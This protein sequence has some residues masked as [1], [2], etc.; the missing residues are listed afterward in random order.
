MERFLLARPDYTLR[1]VGARTRFE[2]ASAAA[3]ALRD[4]TV[5]VVVGALPFETDTPAALV[6]PD[7][8]S[9]DAARPAPGP[10]PSARIVAE[11]PSQSEHV[12]R[13]TRL[14]KLLGEGTLRKVVAARAV[15]LAADTPIDPEA[16]VGHMLRRFPHANGFIVEVGAQL[17]VGASPELLVRRAGAEVTLFPLAGTAPRHA[18]PA[19]DQ[20][21][22]QDLLASEKN[23]AEHSF[24]IDWITER[25]APICDLELPDGPELHATAEVWHLA[26][27][28]RAT[29]RTDATALELAALLHP[30]PAVNGTPFDLAKATIRD[31][32]GD[33]RFYGGAVGW[34]N[35]AGDGDWVVAIRCAELAPDLRSA[36][37]Y[38][39]GGIVAASDPAA[40]LAET[41]AK[42]RTL[43]AP[44]GV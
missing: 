21:Q 27:P 13:V 25:L 10:L 20:A 11:V 43:L 44:L 35:A 24:V 12:A 16:L 34:C 40:E 14:V 7:Y 9:F 31:V 22:A 2:S 36:R 6:A 5:P 38:A 29:L 41:T 18:D 32:E 1:A 8:V 23:R 42:L 17:L 30:T 39:G 33:R 28:I 15:D 37:V 19:V 4:G 26:T 3:Q